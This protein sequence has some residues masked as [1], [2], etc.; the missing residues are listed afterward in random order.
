MQNK[1]QTSQ[2]CADLKNLIIGFLLGLCI[3][4]AIAAASNNYSPGRYQCCHS[5]DDSLAVFVIDTETGQT[6]RLS[7]SDNYDFGTPNARKSIRRNVVPLV[8]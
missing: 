4:F 2:I 1:E 5:G 6:W 7:R 8:E 3:M